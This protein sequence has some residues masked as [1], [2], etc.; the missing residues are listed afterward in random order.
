MHEFYLTSTRDALLIGIPFVAILVMAI[1]RLDSLFAAPKGSSTTENKHRKACGM[2][3]TGEPILV[4][5]DGRP[6]EFRR[7]RK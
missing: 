1:F 4:D 2:D 5:P 6:S 7:N 3:E